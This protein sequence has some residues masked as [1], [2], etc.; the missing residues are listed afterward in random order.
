MMKNQALLM[1]QA[2]QHRDSTLSVSG[3][4]TQ[5]EKSITG[6]PFYRRFL[7]IFAFFYKNY[8]W[9]AVF[10]NTIGEKNEKT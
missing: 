1:V 6:I 3:Y 5:K 4:Y 8:S 2:S 10:Y 9:Y 7:F